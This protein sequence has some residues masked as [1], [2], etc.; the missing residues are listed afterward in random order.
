MNK[1]RGRTRENVSLFHRA[2]SLGMVDSTG[3][4][5]L[6]GGSSGNGIRDDAS[7]ASAP[8]STHGKFDTFLLLLLLL[9]LL[10]PILLLY[11][12]KYVL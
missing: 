7:F 4:N 12:L 1:N 3:G 10:L 2:L 8:S 11:P 9:L 5:G 6:R